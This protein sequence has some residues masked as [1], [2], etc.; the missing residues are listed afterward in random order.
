MRVDHL[1]LVPPPAQAELLHHQRVQEPDQVS[2]RADP[3]ARLREG[4]LEGAR[5]AQ[6][7]PALED[8]DRR[9]AR[10]R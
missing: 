7:V 5:P 10:A 9:P 6:V 1:D 2:A 8:E 4:F 3:P